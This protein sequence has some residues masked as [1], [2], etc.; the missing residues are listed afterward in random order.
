MASSLTNHRS[1]LS[2]TT[3]LWI[4]I[5]SNPLPILLRRSVTV[6]VHLRRRMESRDLQQTT[7]QTTSMADPHSFIVAIMGRIILLLMQMEVSGITTGISMQEELILHLLAG[8]TTLLMQAASVI[9]SLGMR[10]GTKPHWTHRCRRQPVYQPNPWFRWWLLR[11]AP[12]EDGPT[13]DLVG[14]G[15]DPH[16]HLRRMRRKIPGLLQARKLATMTWT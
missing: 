16:P 4:L 10:P 13:G 9:V 3:S 6:K 8:A 5:A 2:S 12:G 1:F 14:M 11:L 15:V 7:S